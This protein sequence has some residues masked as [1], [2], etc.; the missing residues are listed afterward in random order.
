MS[1]HVLPSSE[2]LLPESYAG[3]QVS[4][5]AFDAELRLRRSVELEGCYVLERR[6][7]WTRPPHVDRKHDELGNQVPDDLLVSTRDGYHF[8]AHVSQ[9][10]M[11]RPDKIVEELRAN[12]ND[13]HAPGNNAEQAFQKM[14]SDRAA[15]HAKKRAFR[16]DEW[17]GFYRET[18][19][20]LDRIGDTG[21]HAE[22]MRI[23]NAGGIERYNVTDHRRIKPEDVGLDLNARTSAG[24]SPAQE[25]SD[26][27]PPGTPP[28]RQDGELHDQAAA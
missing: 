22:R 15:A 7:S 2:L 18:F 8:I 9:W 14:V 19:D 16:L 20:I 21:S 23:N 27:H 5:R 11:E 10:F 1:F 24:E 13:L 4:L 25:I 12:D 3:V 17:G 26:V 28:H 6:A